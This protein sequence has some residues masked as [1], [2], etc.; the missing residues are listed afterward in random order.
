MAPP[1]T[2]RCRELDEIVSQHKSGGLG[3][4]LTDKSRTILRFGRCQLLPHRGQLLVDGMPVHM[5][6][7]AFDVLLVL[8]EARGELVTKDE[9]LSRV[10]S[11]R[12]VEEN[13]LQVHV[14]AL[15]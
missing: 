8:V 13:T 2:S 4:Q 10:W 1:S 5:G 12:V 9:I 6:G 14:S 15:R 11:G 7:R 3:M